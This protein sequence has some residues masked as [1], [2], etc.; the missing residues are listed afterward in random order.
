[1]KGGEPTTLWVACNSQGEEVGDSGGGGRVA[2]NQKARL[3]GQ[4]NG[5]WKW[6]RA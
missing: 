3:K 6:P 1:M 2:E 4:K 5:P